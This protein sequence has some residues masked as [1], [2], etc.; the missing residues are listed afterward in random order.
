[1][2]ENERLNVWDHECLGPSSIQ[3]FF[4]YCLLLEVFLDLLS[5]L[6]GVEVP[7]VL[8]TVLSS[9]QLYTTGTLTSG[10]SRSEFCVEIE[11]VVSSGTSRF[12][13]GLDFSV[14]QPLP[15]YGLEEG[16][17]LDILEPIGTMSQ[18]ILGVTLEEN[19]QKCLCLCREELWHPQFCPK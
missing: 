1:M 3:R 5:P 15:V 10:C 8:H 4:S 12:E 2:Q 11:G 13:G 9:I 14:P 17:S 16:V 18:P 7:T 6:F 19:S